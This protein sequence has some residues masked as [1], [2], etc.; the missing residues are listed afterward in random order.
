V[1][2]EIK[3]RGIERAVLEC[4]A[5]SECEASVHSFDHRIVKRCGELND[6]IRRGILLVSYLIDTVRVM[7]EADAGDVWQNHEFVDGELC[8]SVHRAGG[9][10]IAWTVNSAA[11]AVQMMQSGADAVCTDNVAGVREALLAS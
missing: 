6:G 3:A 11:E 1:H 10:V 9:R 7:R 4:I 5:A 8:D 2:V